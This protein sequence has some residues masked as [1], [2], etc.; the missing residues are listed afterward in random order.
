MS[1]QQLDLEELTSVDLRKSRRQYINDEVTINYF[2]K[3]GISSGMNCFEVGAGYGSIAK[4]LAKEVGCTGK[5]FATE[6]KDDCLAVLKTF[7]EKNLLVKAHDITKD[8]IELEKYDFVH[9]RFVLEHIPNREQVLNKLIS[10]LKPGGWLFI[11]DAEYST[12]TLTGSPAYILAMGNYV[13]S[14][15]SKGSNYSW[16]MKLPHLFSKEGLEMV[17]AK[18]NLETFKGGSEQ[19]KYFMSNLYHIKEDLINSNYKEDDLTKALLDLNSPDLW[20]SSPMVLSVVGRKPLL[21]SN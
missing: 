15:E 21:N 3:M 14:I 16:T 13:K 7:E 19:A 18:G 12:T 5:V 4:W 11:E 8:E 20:F 9:A 6:I 2:K 17:E 10:A 1:V